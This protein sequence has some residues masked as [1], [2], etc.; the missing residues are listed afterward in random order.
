MTCS[1]LIVLHHSNE[2]LGAQGHYRALWLYQDLLTIHTLVIVNVLFR[3]MSSH[4]IQCF[5]MILLILTPKNCVTYSDWIFITALVVGLRIQIGGGFCNLSTFGCFRTNITW[6][7]W[8]PTKVIKMA[9]HICPIID[10]S[11]VRYIHGRDW[12]IIRYKWKNPSF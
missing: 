12:S 6:D 4:Q 10:V 8:T 2:T 9:Q 3:V 5:L 1:Y 7:R 11:I